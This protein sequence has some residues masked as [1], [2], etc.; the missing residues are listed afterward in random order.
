MAEARQAQLEDLRMQHQ[1]R[2]LK[3]DLIEP[4]FTKEKVFKRLPLKTVTFNRM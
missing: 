2:W 1:E 4:Q 3:M